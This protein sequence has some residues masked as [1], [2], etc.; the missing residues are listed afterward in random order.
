MAQTGLYW[1]SAEKAV[2]Y[3]ME[4]HDS[5]CLKNGYD[6]ILVLFWVFF[7]AVFFFYSFFFLSFFFW[8]PVIVAIHH[9]LN[10][11]SISGL[12]VTCERVYG[13]AALSLQLCSAM[14]PL[15]SLSRSFERS[16]CLCVLLVMLRGFQHF[17]CVKRPNNQ[18]PHR[19]RAGASP[20]A[21]G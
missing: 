17:S 4:M 12:D 16:L 19:D 5:G 18:W 8:S 3:V 14:C 10:A 20:C 7:V 9:L 11:L 1:V 13:G 21:T 15:L 2:A 6:H